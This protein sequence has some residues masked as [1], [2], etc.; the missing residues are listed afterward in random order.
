MA[1]IQLIVAAVRQ[2]FRTLETRKLAQRD[3]DGYA[4]YPQ[5]DEFL[6]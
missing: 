1:I 5:G 4:K 2:Y 6:L 3:R